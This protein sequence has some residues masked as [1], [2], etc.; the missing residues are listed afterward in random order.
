MLFRLRAQAPLRT[1]HRREGED[2]RNPCS[3]TIGS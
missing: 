1:A 2:K 3:E